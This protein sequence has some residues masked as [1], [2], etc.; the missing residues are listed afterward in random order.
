MKS[1]RREGRQAAMR[2][3]PGSTT[4]TAMAATDSQVGSEYTSI[5]LK[6]TKRAIEVIIPLE[7]RVSLNCGSESI[8]LTENLSGRP[9][10]IRSFGGSLCE[11]STRLE[12]EE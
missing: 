3:I 4:V 2:Y 7:N 5:T 12:A 8:E 9:R 11:V 6:M 1:G 10:S